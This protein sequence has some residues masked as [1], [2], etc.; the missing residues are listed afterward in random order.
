MYSLAGLA[1]PPIWKGEEEIYGLCSVDTEF[2]SNLINQSINHK[3]R[4]G[5]QGETETETETGRNLYHH[6]QSTNER[7]PDPTRTSKSKN[8]MPIT[9]HIVSNAGPRSHEQRKPRGE[10]YALSKSPKLSA[11]QTPPLTSLKISTSV[12]KTSAS[13]YAKSAG[14]WMWSISAIS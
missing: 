13:R 8:P 3:N 10:T 1:G 7:T 12:A 11:E 9:T 6:H 14:A 2:N 5:Y 4:K